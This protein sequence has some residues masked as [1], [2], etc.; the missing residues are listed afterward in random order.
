MKYIGTT[1]TYD[2]CFVDLRKLKDRLLDANIII[3]KELTEDLRSFLVRNKNR[4]IL[5]HTVTGLGNSR[6]E[7]GVK[8]PD[9]ELVR[10]MD[11]IN[12]G[13]PIRQYV[14]RIDPIV[15]IGNLGVLALDHV[16]SNWSHEL[17]SLGNKYRGVKIRCRISILDLYPHVKDRFLKLGIDL[18][19]K[20]FSEVSDDQL[21]SIKRVLDKYSFRFTYE[22][23]AEPRL[24][25]ITDH[26]G[27][28]S[29]ADLRILREDPKEYGF[30]SVPQR[31]TCLCL[32]KKQI[33]GVKPG[34]CPHNCVYCYWK[35]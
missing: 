25:G 33:L 14:L 17:D 9:V 2:P 11:L 26:V 20:G 30:P 5:H 19:N 8:D 6:I 7:P 27:C 15:N 34:R 21:T 1:E 35:D 18:S 23:C 10:F 3:T 22:S 31:S 29:D 4:C 12:A 28:A 13:F 32:A 24:A 16:L